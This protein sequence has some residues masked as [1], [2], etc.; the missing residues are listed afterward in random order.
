MKLILLIIVL[1][2]LFLLIQIIYTT[3]GAL[4]ADHNSDNTFHTNN[5]LDEFDDVNVI[6]SPS[7]AMPYMWVYW[8]IRNNSLSPPDYIQMCLE[9][10]QKNGSRYFNVV[11]LDEKK[12]IRLYSQSTSRY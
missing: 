7:K 3:Q 4:L 11:L 2:I 5:S 12:H 1:L 9:L 8:E 6:K 10:I